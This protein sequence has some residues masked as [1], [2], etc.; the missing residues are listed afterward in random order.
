MAKNV[1]LI[2]LFSIILI[3]S[4]TSTKQSESATSEAAVL[5]NY[6]ERDVLNELMA[7]L[8]KRDSSAFTPE[9]S[10]RIPALTKIST[11][12]LI[13]H[14]FVIYGDDDRYNI[15]EDKVTATQRINAPKV[16]C[17]VHKNK[18]VPYTNGTFNLKKDK[19]LGG[20]YELCNTEQR[21]FDE[22]LISFGSG[23]AISPDT[24]VTA[25]HCLNNIK[26]EDIRIVYG[27]QVNTGNNINLVI[28]AQDIYYPI[29]VTTPALLNK[30]IDVALLKLNK[31]VPI[32]RVV[33]Y[34]RAGK[35][36]SE[37]KLY[38]IGHP[39]GLPLKFTLNASIV[40]NSPKAFFVTNAD[41]YKGN[42]GSPVFNA[43]GDFVEG[44]LVRGEEKGYSFFPDQKCAMGF[45]CVQDGSDCQGEDVTRISELLPF[46]K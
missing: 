35:V 28:K 29:Q 16:A 44:I 17:L 1:I 30:Q 22:P 45:K 43:S 37:D 27:Y 42:S 31:K 34:R 4:C 14:M 9:I 32:E 39:C 11:E 18:L 15:F 24:F 12:A 3:S 46:I 38:V 23:F 20:Y 19:T 40:N 41:T 21:F 13:E 5:N 7:R 6:S 10:F 2:C 8:P 36:A 26:F 25:G 33:K